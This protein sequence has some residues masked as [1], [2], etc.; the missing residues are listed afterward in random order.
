LADVA[1]MNVVFGLLGEIFAPM[2][3]AACE[4]RVSSN[5]LFCEP[6]AT[7]VVPAQP[8]RIGHHALFEYGGAVA[9]AIVRM[10]Y[11]GRYDLA[12][13]F[14]AALAAG[15]VTHKAR[16]PEGRAG[17]VTLAD[18]VDVVVPVPLHQARLVERGYDQAALL[19]GPV[20]ASLGVVHAPRA[21]LRTRPTPRQASLDRLAR[22]ANVAAAF[23]CRGG[24]AV[25]G[26]RVLLVDDVRTTGATLAACAEAL[27][28]GGASAVHTAVLATRDRGICADQDVIRG[29]ISADQGGEMP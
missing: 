3:C 8:Q 21:L 17:L 1:D 7:S 28:E 20:A 18:A 23:A 16:A 22:A 12:C 6:C 9:T 14:A 13:R 26:R 27:R 15:L 4:A 5:I 25:A 24:S 11:A 2:E 29:A 10:K 19:A